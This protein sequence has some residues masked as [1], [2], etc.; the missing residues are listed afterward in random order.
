MRPIDRLVMDAVRCISCGAGFGKCDC[1]AK[2]KK[3]VDD[4][5]ARLMAIEDDAEFLAECAKVGVRP[6][7]KQRSQNILRK[8]V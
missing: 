7:R 8:D 2:A 1:A 3:R 5:Y 4:E 6:E